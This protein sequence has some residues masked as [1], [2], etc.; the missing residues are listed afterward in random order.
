MTEMDILTWAALY[1][2]ASRFIKDAT[3]GLFRG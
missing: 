2:A 3:G 1:L